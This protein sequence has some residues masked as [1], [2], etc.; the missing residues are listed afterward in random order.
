MLA[1]GGRGYSFFFLRPGI[2]DWQVTRTVTLY[3]RRFASMTESRSSKQTS[4]HHRSC[5]RVGDARVSALST[6][7]REPYRTALT[8]HEASVGV[9]PTKTFQ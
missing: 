5:S 1:T 7:V 2:W 6:I 3:M 9:S 4:T 8:P